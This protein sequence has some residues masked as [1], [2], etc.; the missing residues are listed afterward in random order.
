VPPEELPNVIDRLLP[1]LVS[2][3]DASAKKSLDIVL[4]SLWDLLRARRNGE[5]R[6]YVLSAALVIPISKSIVSGARFIT[7]KK[8]VRYMPYHFII[9]LNQHR[10]PSVHSSSPA[11]SARRPIRYSA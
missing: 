11:C 8:L 2:K 4:L 5:Y 9:S 6:D 7:G 3:D 1:P 10:K